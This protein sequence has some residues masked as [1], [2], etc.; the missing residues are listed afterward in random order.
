MKTANT[1][2]TKTAENKSSAVAKSLGSLLGDSYALLGQLHVAHWNVEGPNFHSLHIAFQAQY[3]EVFVAIDEVAER[4]RAL[5]AFSPG[6]LKT[7]AA[8]SS[9]SEL[10][11]EEIPSKDYVAHLVECHEIV[12]DTAMK[13]RDLAEKEGDLETQD[14]VIG[15]IRTHEKYLWMLRA[16]LK[17][18]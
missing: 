7:L 15:R 12:V 5:G 16:H 1:S 4:I 10:P 3:E 13:T 14:L 17:N 9:I 11:I 2:S 8:L 6:G 18:L